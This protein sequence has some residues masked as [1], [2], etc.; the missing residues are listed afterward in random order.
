VTKHIKFLLLM[1]EKEMIDILV[2]RI[3][4]S[5]EREHSVSVMETLSD[6]IHEQQEKDENF[7]MRITNVIIEKLSM[8]VTKDNHYYRE[9]SGKDSI[10][11][12]N[13]NYKTQRWFEKHPI[14][15]E[16]FKGLLTAFFTLAVGII[17]W[18]LQNQKEDRENKELKRQ[19]EAITYKVDSLTKAPLYLK[20]K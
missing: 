19:L 2:D 6:F 20:M 15:Y 1:S 7:E 18:L 10:I 13:P 16:Y 5:L 11:S 17:L 9:K 4:S 14:L 12:L 3:K 8:A